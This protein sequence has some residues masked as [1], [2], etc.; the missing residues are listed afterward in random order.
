MMSA[1][2]ANIMGKKEGISKVFINSITDFS[3]LRK[4]IIS[5]AYAMYRNIFS[6]ILS[7]SSFYMIN[8]NA[9]S[10]TSKKKLDCLVWYHFQA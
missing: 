5:S 10:K 7:I 2:Y 1:L 9:I 8:K 6:K 3:S 4:N